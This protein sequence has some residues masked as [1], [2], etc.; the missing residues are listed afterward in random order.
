MPQQ[1]SSICSR[2]RILSSGGGASK[3]F[4][5]WA[6]RGGGGG[7]CLDSSS[8]NMRFCLFDEREVLQMHKKM[9]KAVVGSRC[10]END[11]KMGTKLRHPSGF[12]EI[13]SVGDCLQM[14][15]HSF[16]VRI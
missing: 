7:L 4:E 3:P 2:N 16:R 5:D 10:V 8:I 6:I 12:Y 15:K 14:G 13:T 11:C 9:L 1:S